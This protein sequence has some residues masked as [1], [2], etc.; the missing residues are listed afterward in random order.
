MPNPIDEA[1]SINRTIASIARG[2][3]VG[4]AIEFYDAIVE[5]AEA[6]ADALR[7]DNEER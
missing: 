7:E 5:D 2:M 1:A 3:T 6:A 4:E